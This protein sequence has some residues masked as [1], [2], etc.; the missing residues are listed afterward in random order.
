MVIISKYSNTVE[1]NLKT[2][3][4]ASGISKLQAEI[5]KTQDALR[6][7]SAQ[8]L[9]GDKSA[10][11]AIQEIEKL[12]RA[13]TTS[14][15]SRVGML[16]MNKFTAELTK[17]KTNLAGLQQEF[18]KAGITGQT[19]F[20]QVIGR[21]GKLDTGVKSTSKAVDKIFNT[22]GN[23]VRWGIVS[24]AFN[25]MSNSIYKS[26]EYVKELD[27][28][29]TQIMLVTDY[30]R[31]NMNDF[32]KNA[33]EAAKNLGSTT[34]AMTNASLVF[35]QQGFNLDQS[36][37]LAELSTKLANASQ[38][39]TATTSD[40]I[41]AYMNAYGLDK[42]MNALHGAM[43]AWAQVANVSAAD[44][45]ELAQASQKAA[46]TA[47]TVGVSMDQLNGQIA[48]I[49]SVTREA[50]E[51]IGNG[52]KTL[53]A[54]FSDLEAGETLED[55]VS[56][57]KVTSQL[58]KYGVQVLDGEGQMRGVGDI[59]EDLME[60]WS[61][62]D[63]TQK[64]AVA[65][66]VAG[67][68]QLSR[69]EALMNR[70]DLYDEYKG[71]SESADGTLD[72]MNEEF[73]DSLEGRMNK[74]QATFEG[75]FNSMF[76]TD[77]IYPFI[78]ALTAALELVD[79]FVQ[80]IGGGGQ[81][82]LAF[83][84][85][86]TKV[87]SKQ[88]AENIANTVQAYTDN[89]AVKAN[90]KMAKQN[91]ESLGLKD[92][93][94]QYNKPIVDFATTGMK[95][96]NIMSDS[97]KINFNDNLEKTVKLNNEVI[98]SEA[99]L[100]EVAAATNLLYQDRLETKQNM[101]SIEKDE[102]GNLSWKIGEQLMPQ[103]AAGTALG[104]EDAKAYKNYD[105]SDSLEGSV[106]ALVALSNQ[107]ESYVSLQ[108]QVDKDN[109]WSKVEHNID[110][111]RE[112]V[113]KL[114]SV[115]TGLDDITAVKDLDKEME[116]A[117]QEA[118]EMAQA[119]Q[120]FMSVTDITSDK[121]LDVNKIKSAIEEVKN[122]ALTEQKVIEG[123][124]KGNFIQNPEDLNRLL[125]IFN[126]A[127]VAADEQNKIDAETQKGLELQAKLNNVINLTSAV[128][129][130]AFAWTSFQELGSLLANDDLSLGEKAIQLVTNL[131]FT[132]PQLIMGIH[133]LNTAVKDTKA[134]STFTTFLEKIIAN[135][136][137]AATGTLAVG[138]AAGTAGAAATGASTGVGLLSK[139]LNLLKGSLG[140][141]G[142]AF[143]AFSAIAGTVSFIV[144]Q[145]KKDIE[146]LTS[147]AN[148]AVE[149]MNN[150]Q[151]NLNNFNN[152][153]EGYKEGTVSSE[154][155]EE[156]ATSLNDVLG[157]QSAK[158]QAAVGNWDAYAASV[159]KA[160]QEQ[161]LANQ[162]TMQANTW[163]KEKEFVEQ[164]G[165]FGINSDHSTSKNWNND[166]LNK[167]WQNATSLSAGGK[168]G[169]GTDWGFAEDTS[170]SQRIQDLE[171][172]DQAFQN[173]IN[174]ANNV[175]NNISDTAS[176][177]YQE[178]QD[179]LNSLQNSYNEFTAFK[180]QYS[181]TI[182]A[183]QEAYQ[184]QA[185]NLLAAHSNDQ[186]YQYTGGT[187][188]EYTEQI[189][190]ALQADGIQ[191]SQQVIDAFVQ[192]MM[193]ADT[194]SAQA[195]AAQAGMEDA[196]EAFSSQMND[197]VSVSLQSD[198]SFR[199]SFESYGI[200]TSKYS[201]EISSILT[202]S[203]LNQVKNSSLSAEDQAT[204]LSSLDWSQ[205]IENILAA[206]SQSID[207]GDISA[208]QNMANPEDYGDQ[209]R[210]SRLTE[211][212]GLDESTID[213]YYDIQEAA[214]ELGDAQDELAEKSKDAAE[215]A[216]EVK[217]AYGEESDEFKEASKEARK[218]ERDLDAYN[219]T[220]EDLVDMALQSQKG[221][222]ELSETIEDN[223][224][225]LRDGDK[226]SI[227]YAEA[228][229]T[230]RQA[231]ADLVNV[232]KEDIS[233]EFIAENLDDIEKAAYGD[234]EAIQRL[235]AAA[236]NEILLKI[237]KTGNL[238]PENLD[239]LQQKALELSAMTIEPYATLDDA[240]F[241]ASLNNMIASGQI[242]ADQVQSYL[243]S[244]GYDPVITEEPGPEQ[245]IM[246]IKG[247][248]IDF[249]I[250]GQRLG[251][252]T[253]PD[254]TIMG[255]ASMPKI[256]SIQ[257]IGGGGHTPVS[258]TARGNRPSGGGRKGGGGGRGGGGKGG[259]GGK[260]YEPKEN[261]DPIDNKVDRYEK[262][263]TQLGAIGA[264]YEKINSEQERLTGDKL[265][266][267]LQK[268]NELLL[269]QI[270]LYQEKLKIQQQ[271]AE[272][273]KNKLSSQFGITYDSEGFMTNYAKVHQQLIDE[274]NRIGNQY[275][276]LGSEEAEKALD[277][278]YEAAQ[279]RLD[280]FEELYKRYDELLSS[281]IKDTIQQIED[282]KDSIEDMRIEIFKTSVE[283][284][285][286]IKE[287]KQELA[288]FNQ[289]S[290]IW[291]DDDPFEKAKQSVLELG[292][293]WDGAIDNADKYYDDL[294]AKEQEA[295][296]KAA[297]EEG[298]KYHNDR[299]AKLQT[300]KANQGKGTLE[301]GGTGFFDM[302]FSNVM[303]MMKEIEQFEK[304]GSSTTFG[305]NSAAMYET[306]LDVLKQANSNLNDYKDKVLDLRDLIN[307]MV[308]EILEKQEERM[309][310]YQDINDELEHQID[311]ITMIHGEEAYDQ[312]KQAYAAQ[313]TNTKNQISEMNQT[314]AANKELLAQMEAAGDTSSD[315]YKALKDNIADTQKELNS[316]VQSSIENIRKQQELT[317]KSITDSW[318]KDA[319]G[320][321]L[322][323]MQTEWELINRNADY[324]LDDVN[325]AYN[326][327]KL[328]GKYLELLDQSNDLG[329][330]N[331]ITAQMKEQLKYL[332]EKKNLSEYDV[333]YANAQLDILQKRIALEEAQRN[334][335]QM[336]LRR[337]SQGN[338]SYVYTTNEGDVANAQSG[339]LDAQNNAYNL[340]K[341]QMQQ[342]Q[343]DSLS[344]L[345]DAKSLI[346]SIWTNANL[347]LEEKKKRTET[348][349]GSLKEYLAATSEQLGV[350][351]QNIIND[352]L[353]MCEALTDENKTGLQE[354]YEEIIN[355]NKDAFDKI[356]E[357][358]STSLTDWLQSLDKF[359]QDTTDKFD[360]LYGEMED[361]ESQIDDIGDLVGQN[362]DDMT[363]SIQ[364]TLDKTEELRTSTQ[365]FI[366]DLQK[367]SGAV[368]DAEK[369]MAYYRDKITEANNE[370]SMYQQKVN[371]L[372][373]KLEQAERE[374]ADM[375][376]EI[377]KMQD[378][379]AAR[380]QAAN[381]GGGGG[382]G[383]NGQANSAMAW[384][385]A[386]AIWTY[387]GKSGWGNNPIRSTKLKKAYGDA[388][389]REVQS[390]INANARSGKL[391]NYDSMKYSSYSLIGY[392][393][394][395]YTGTWGDKTF[396]DKN[397]KLAVLHQKE[398]ILNATD[399]ENIL[400]TVSA[401]RDLVAG[402]KTQALN[403]LS[404]TSAIGGMATKETAQDV[405]QNVHITAEFPNVS[406]SS[407][408]E[409]ALLNL[410]ERA[411][412]Y[413]FKNN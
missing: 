399:T 300:A 159:N 172:F 290:K 357:R 311:L 103:F 338:Y 270:E 396:D 129:D 219:D 201:E 83:G 261:K 225:I 157:D 101:L 199:E 60:V 286:N 211:G 381:G 266:K 188:A 30:S 165:F 253:I 321:D 318:V 374:K 200:D 363:G 257:S 224:K 65:Q 5:R 406:S 92:V 42:D 260:S 68:Y 273:V 99:Q 125:E 22:I 112:S 238:T 206:V 19:A 109:T 37:Q 152:L 356:D 389:A 196:T 370:M 158:V 248:S 55:G 113:K 35:A 126:K 222:E 244:I 176:Q 82:L 322:D 174:E 78:D 166:I 111:T 308:D 217:D 359:N 143:I 48:A 164:P 193:N 70:S 312:L 376:A 180:G 407:E 51:Q 283:A 346:D 205:P 294:I 41:T 74:L 245:P 69:F 191:A 84:N 173:A 310:A 26:V 209:E 110:V 15:N 123:L 139:A 147:A 7:L 292:E 87:F 189:K 40:Q 215:K 285:D 32:A 119:I 277:K 138:S 343:A 128:G 239:Y 28:S 46:S 360:S 279:K 243:N 203:V 151:P 31:E 272:E 62:L 382:G 384:G 393:T 341:E 212:Y 121:E 146:N 148:D 297:T 388:F 155:L 392:D 319:L 221:M 329:I 296:N 230:T 352:F 387:G 154:Q 167:A 76:E 61:S 142:L 57:G 183:V 373:S 4:D 71:A 314:L 313:L 56:L 160:A 250:L 255:Q 114:C 156:A 117:S 134:F 184:E 163:Q 281:D 150:I 333:Q 208:A 52:L 10:S 228:M 136:M 306:A 218:A 317:V 131:T 303:D 291:F 194:E 133:T 16:D 9:I 299:I 267:N 91:L 375:R 362:F 364:G 130:L 246:T 330:Q 162:S 323:W 17:S 107:V 249:D 214:Y 365:G 120:K 332:R 397:G 302:Q 59:M 377:Q 8:E 276:G 132:L 305:E 106:N 309:Q 368:A 89:T 97:Q 108:K 355:G 320:T 63:Q 66:T 192:G 3:L 386:Q 104:M 20:N 367:M 282:L 198:D 33:N 254:M 187:I 380:Q 64:A 398:L 325:K 144:G 372:G 2:T 77:D 242:T 161:A 95:Y 124:G 252:I 105:L 43:D 102:N 73:V 100:K 226:N 413:A 284:L 405:N 47:N 347:S 177:E 237:N 181:D 264:D 23:T 67:K 90:S 366:S 115:M 81:V 265:A 86:A 179:N 127:K 213:T 171:N 29:L 275:S 170:A 289:S 336:K 93:E 394:G 256:E 411:I 14:F 149:K 271:E 58:E 280:T 233:P 361:Y 268:Q 345:S 234:V 269:H 197:K 408:I 371:E 335:S 21:L 202:E 227:E 383:A 287:I 401:V 403:S 379:E 326:I 327:Q 13:L 207:S 349:I 236:A 186:A 50:P 369:S 348:I 53:Y 295:A 85:I 251:G 195:L 390:I 182:S 36:S 12:Q 216:E 45:A 409:N 344:A 262:V 395:G 210:R 98:E 412:Q 153:Y 141:V 342:T 178:A 354:T 247:S 288:E 44:V 24:S 331:Q 391:V 258:S 339:L 274:V 25:Q 351:E 263:E 231:V 185:D 358:W 137:P 229:D 79:N 140:L 402:L 118:K 116:D 49:E 410:N 54:R 315:A 204:L 122:L 72:Q 34:T 94:N 337:D 385:I 88:L 340:S 18:A 11:K 301:E 6:V 307:D 169:G 278:Q 96:S 38:Q 135:A 75:I 328:Q 350:S 241:I 316:L 304:T 223:A 404:I 1:Y 240:Q 293:F 39:D 168:I 27:D 145:S 232:S 378:A 175:L 324:Y 235:R 190:A 259:G 298:K 220:Q 400:A 80:S 334:K 353:G